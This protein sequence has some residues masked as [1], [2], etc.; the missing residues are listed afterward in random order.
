MRSYRGLWDICFTTVWNLNSIHGLD[1][2]RKRMTHAARK[3]ALT[4]LKVQSKDEMIDRMEIC[5]KG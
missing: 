2:D 1:L 5:W 3:M 4:A